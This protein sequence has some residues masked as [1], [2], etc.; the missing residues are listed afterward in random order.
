VEALAIFDPG[1]HGLVLTDLHMP[2]VDGIA[3]TT[4]LRSGQAEGARV[5]IVALTADALPAT[6]SRC[7]EAGMDGWLTK[8]IDS[9]AL[10]DC[11]GRSLPQAVAL[12]RPDKPRDASPAVAS[13]G[14]FPALAIDI[15]PAIF[16]IARIAEPFGGWN[17]EARGFMS[18]FLLE[19]P[20]KLRPLSDA[21]AADDPARARFAA[22]A[23]KGAA[24]S[25]GATRLGRTAAEM[26]NCLD[27]R[28]MASARTY[29]PLLTACSDELNRTLSVLLERKGA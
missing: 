10:Q 9:R 23:L 12:R 15:D 14:A 1:K 13:D 25:A 24:L 22:H 5:P 17:D 8:P 2:R 16:D 6:R 21:M 27:A 28:D 26:Q 4:A 11:I 29:E 18:D 7:L 19:L 20:A 3:L